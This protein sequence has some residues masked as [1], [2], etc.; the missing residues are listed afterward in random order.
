MMLID[1]T[2]VHLCAHLI[3]T[4]KVLRAVTEVKVQLKQPSWQALSFCSVGICSL[5]AF[6]FSK[7]ITFYLL[8]QLSVTLLYSLIDLLVEYLQ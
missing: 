2:G 5:L 6:L 1:Q 8:Q 7:S 4:L 3:S